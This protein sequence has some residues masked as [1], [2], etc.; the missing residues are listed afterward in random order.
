VFNPERLL[1]PEGARPGQ[2]MPFG[3]GSRYC[4]GAGLAMAEMK[5]CAVVLVCC[6]ICGRA[7]GQHCA[8]CWKPQPLQAP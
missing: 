2:Q 1:T 8:Q 7:G 6:G 4:L 3:A 5:V